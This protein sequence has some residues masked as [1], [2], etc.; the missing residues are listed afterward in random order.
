[1]I[2]FFRRALSSWLVLGMLGVIMIAFIITGVGSPGAG[3]VSLFGEWVAKVGNQKLTP[4]MVEARVQSQLQAER[5]RN[6]GI[7]LPA[8]IA[9]GGLDRT[10]DQMIN[11]RALEAFALAHG[12]ASSRRLVD[13]E[14][15]TIQ[16]F[17]GPT[18]SFDRG[19][20]LRAIGSAGMTEEQVREDIARDKLVNSLVIPAQGGAR[21]S[22]KM[23][24]LYG[25]L[26]LEARTGEIAIVP[27]GAVA[28]GGAPG[29]AELNT[30]YAR[31]AIRYTVPETRVVRYALFDRSRFAETVSITEAE[32]AQAYKA[33][34]AKFTGKQTRV[35]SQA[36]V[37]SQQA[38]QAIVAKARTGA[39]IA[40]AAKAAGA[41]IVTLAPQ[42]EASFAGL[43]SPAAAKAG[44]AA[45]TGTVIDAQKTPFGWN[46]IRVDAINAASSQ[47]LDSVRAQLS[48]T[49]R[50][51]KMDG[52]LA[53]FVTK[54]ED[55]IADGATFADVAKANGL[56]VVTTPPITSSG[57]APDQP[58]FRSDSAIPPV[59]KD[60]F[61]AAPDDD[62]SVVTLI[63]GRS[64]ALYDLDKIAPA[65]PRP[66]AAIR[67]QVAADF[68]ADRAAKAAKRVADA[69]LA[70][71][72]GG[73][74]LA[75]AIASA[76]MPLPP[77][78]P[79]SARRIDL[80]QGNTPVPPPVQLMFSMAK[81][82]AKLL[83]M[84]D[85]QGWYVVHLTGT[86][87]GDA[88]TMPGLMERTQQEMAASL[89]EEYVA[90]LASAIRKDVG[91]ER[92]P[93]ALAAL[94]RRLTGAPS[95]P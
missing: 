68:M 18:G 40:D 80:A 86:T 57:M 59:I 63:A 29:E 8:F 26:L 13:S 47:S 9:Q 94:R 49:I 5:Q 71:V 69:I 55:A 61:Q 15:A 37:P 1:M 32:I 4:E 34:A 28:T 74:T 35:F 33:D 72:N 79:I 83:A 77:A 36:V 84:P 75:A 3:G 23:A 17:R 53:E 30:F 70:K 19:T 41:D 89:G 46:V 93:S 10:L 24:S 85:N 95:R 64:Y 62:A 31:N 38:A 27:G 78:R 45:T 50:Q 92:N 20:F 90:Q 44:F 67:Q 81:G 54:L 58:N 76:G 56:S 51:R 2:S 65:A 60:A 52:A 22:N 91:V 12:M 87:P 14:I 7:E 11:T 16:A 48:E 66:L 88:R 6:A 42:D 82:K 21:A 43:T 73:A 39:S 25:S